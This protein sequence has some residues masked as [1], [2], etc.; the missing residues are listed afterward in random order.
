MDLSWDAASDV[1]HY[2][3]SRDARTVAHG[4]TETS[5]RDR[6][7]EP[8]TRY[9][10]TVVGVGVD[11]DET[12]PGHASVKTGTPPVADA[13]LEGSFG[14]VMHVDH[15]SGTTAPVSGGGVLFRFEPNCA[16]GPCSVRWTVRSRA[17]DADLPRSGGI[18]GGTLHTPFLIKSCHGTEIDETVKVHL[19]VMKAAPIHHAW[20]ATRIEGTVDETSSLS[21]CLAASIDW[22]VRGP[23]R[24]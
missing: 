1:D 17:T 13:R 19:R 20:R 24:P 8:G 6:D 10:Y 2:V 11:G 5:W 16:R 9:V 3:V 23:L 7:V 15:A 18:Y 4:V 21:G 14:M 12:L 22:N